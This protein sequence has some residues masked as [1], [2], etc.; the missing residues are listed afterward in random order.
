MLDAIDSHLG[1]RKLHIVAAPGAGKTS[2]G[3][4]VIRR[5]GNSTLILSPTRIVRNQWL[6]RLEDFL[7]ENTSAI[8]D[9]CSTDLHEPHVITSVTY[10]ALHS[11]YREAEE[12]STGDTSTDAN[13]APPT[14]QIDQ[15]ASILQSN[16]VKTLVL[17]E[18]HHL[19][20]AWWKALTHLTEQLPDLHI[21]SLTATP[22][23]DAVGH[24]WARYQA[25]C[26]PIDEEISVPELVKAGTLCP[27]QDFCYMTALGDET[28]E[29]LRGYDRAVADTI[30]SLETDREFFQA[31]LSHP[32]LHTQE[33]DIVELLDDTE[34]AFGLLSYLKHNNASIPKKLLRPLDARTADLPVMNRRWWGIVIRRVLFSGDFDETDNIEALRKRLKKMLRAKQLLK[35]RQLQFDVSISLRQKL[36][37]TPEKI[38]ACV[39]IYKLEQ[40]CRGEQLRQVILTD[41]IRDETI[42]DIDTPPDQLGAWPVFR[43]LLL[44]TSLEEARGFA[45]LTGRYGILHRQQWLNGDETAITVRGA[46]F[47]HDYLILEGSSHQL[48]RYF[49][50]RLITGDLHVLIGTRA[51]LGEGWDC[52]VVNSLVLASYVGAFVS[53]NQMRGRALR[54]DKN[55]PE[56]VAS[57]WHLVAI[58]EDTDSG[59]WDYISLYERFR[60][61][62]GLHNDND[63]IES[64]VERLQLPAIDPTTHRF[65]QK[66]AIKVNNRRMANQLSRLPSIKTRW[67]RATTA[68]DNYRVI[69]SIRVKQ[70]TSLRVVHFSNTLSWLLFEAGLAFAAGYSYVV[71]PFQYVR[72][73]DGDFT[74]QLLM[75]AFGAGALWALPKLGKALY[76]LVKHLPV[77]GSIK[78]I[79]GALKSALCETNLIKTEEQKLKVVSNNVAGKW[80]ISLQ[81]GDFYESSLFA[82]CLNELLGPVENPRYLI[83]RKSAWR[84]DYHPLPTV[85]ATHKA[86]AECFF[87]HWRKR[88]CNGELIYTRREDGRSILLK[89]RSRNFAG[90][91]VPKHERLDQWQ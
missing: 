69:P 57:I 82:D 37:H 70:P 9:W 76:G 75:I 89:A 47:N 84:T 21:I 79:A 46:A 25:L 20:S 54:V 81:G 17:D 90:I 31:V 51:L 23:Y 18:A 64:G 61:F 29:Q 3:L 58:H 74:G 44:N 32:W 35:G 53:T 52:P 60:T 24:N 71:E 26:G 91:F 42:G 19:Q 11:L 6:E 15:L 48:T 77:D 78:Q 45:M 7:P 27:H 67:T 62:V 8:P 4:E 41:F 39:N 1:D 59:L 10:Q 36:R 85:L 73:N 33:V 28:L 14:R 40:Q 56:K 50:E 83:T 13:E 86:K 88:V 12:E 80:T 34:F 49:T 66:L 87:Q 16:Q 43:A 65:A 38:T 63:N 68:V 22:P 2:L 55:Q 5:L 72:I 30:L